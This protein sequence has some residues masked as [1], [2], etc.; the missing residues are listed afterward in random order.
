MKNFL[1]FFI[2]NKKKTSSSPEPIRGHTTHLKLSSGLVVQEGKII[3]ESVYTVVHEGILL[4]MGDRVAIK[5]I[6][7]AQP[8]DIEIDL[9]ISFYE[10][11]NSWNNPSL[12]RYYGI[13]YN[14][15]TRE[16]IIVTEF[17]PLDIKDIK[18]LTYKEYQIKNYIRQ[19]LKIMEEL[20]QKQLT[21]IG[22][23]PSNILALVDGTIMIR[24]YVATDYLAHLQ[25]ISV[26]SEPDPVIV[27]TIPSDPSQQQLEAHRYP[28][29]GRQNSVTQ[30]PNDF[31]GV[32]VVLKDFYM[33]QGK[34]RAEL[35]LS[36]EY[37][38]FIKLLGEVSR[39]EPENV[40]FERLY[41]HPFLSAL[42]RALKHHAIETAISEPQRQKLSPKKRSTSEIM[43][44]P[45]LRAHAEKEEDFVTQMYKVDTQFTPQKKKNWREDLKV[46][47][48]NMTGQSFIGKVSER[49]KIPPKE[50]EEKFLSEQKDL[51]KQQEDLLLMM[52]Q[53]MNTEQ[54]PECISF[55]NIKT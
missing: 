19:I 34:P 41:N 30:P 45:K 32:I 28:S 20:T 9:L 11:T 12:V 13:D 29:A 6:R 49:S 55:K 46:I 27:T 23:K 22:I 33:V 25:Q 31:I 42:E 8:V 17:G 36:P 50:N 54:D 10:T 51:E 2:C 43:F 47:V 18:R 38:S 44:E 4:P 7:F 37:S 5:K 40:D 52:M 16:L 53:Q 21:N 35:D 3:H 26:P 15:L 1:S 39:L 24:D 14:P 48:K